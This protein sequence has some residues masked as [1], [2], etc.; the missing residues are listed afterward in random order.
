MITREAIRELAEF[1][2]PENCAISF[3][4]QP[5]TPQDQSH[6]QEAILVK[7][8]VRD[9]LKNTEKGGRNACARADLQRILEIADRLHGNGGK[10]KAIFASSKEGIWHEFDLPASIPGTRLII[11]RRFHLKPLAPVIENRPRVVACLIDR[12]KARLF[13]FENDRVNELVDFFNEL[14]RRGRSD[15][16][17]GYDAGHVERHVAND[18][19]QHYKTVADALL[20]M[21]ERDGFDTLAI[22][23][24][25]DTWNEIYPSL[26][27]YLQQALL[28]QFRIDP[29]IASADDVKNRLLDLLDENDIRRRHHLVKNVIGEAHR[30]A[31]GAIG[32]RRVLRSLET[33]EIQTLMVGEHLHCAGSE[34]KNCGHLDLKQAGECSVCTHEVTPVEDLTDAIIGHA[35]RNGIEVVYISGDRDFEKAG[36]VGALLRFRA[37]QNTAMKLAS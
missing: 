18:A 37:D 23:C 12:T 20:T 13:K 6:R 33:G 15:G 19:N 26:H 36:H 1:E 7:D 8:L 31:R 25:D 3:Y 34:C 21:Y 16:W 30:N 4:Y 22:G 32:M 29:A 28:G 10:A 35:I 24:R 9:A 14:P 11:N 2:S 17:G 27:K 5:E